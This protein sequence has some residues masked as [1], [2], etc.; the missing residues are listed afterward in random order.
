MPR[1]EE[2]LTKAIARVERALTAA[3]AENPLA[4][5]AILAMAAHSQMRACLVDLADSVGPAHKAKIDAALRYANGEE[6][7]TP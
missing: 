6:V 4:E 5:V 7:P 2:A 3:K 1:N